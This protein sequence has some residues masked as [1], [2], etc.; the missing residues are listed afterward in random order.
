M[1]NKKKGK[2]TKFKDREHRFPEVRK[3]LKHEGRYMQKHKLMPE[4]QYQNIKLIIVS[5]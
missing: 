5:C 1:K 3:W 2:R 4:N